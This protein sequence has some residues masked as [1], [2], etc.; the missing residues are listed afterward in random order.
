MFPFIPSLMTPPLQES[1]QGKQRFIHEF[2]GSSWNSLTLR[3]RRAVFIRFFKKKNRN[4]T[5]TNVSKSDL[6]QPCEMNYIQQY[7]QNEELE[8][9]ITTP[10]FKLEASKS[11]VPESCEVNHQYLQCFGMRNCKKRLGQQIATQKKHLKHL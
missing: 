11:E 9:I 5:H 2:L 7:H 4:L 8:Q 1:S 10:R 6:W 3:D